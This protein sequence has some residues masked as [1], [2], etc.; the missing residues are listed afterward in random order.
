MILDTLIDLYGKFTLDYKRQ[1]SAKTLRFL[2]GRLALI[3]D[4]LN[5][6]E[7]NLEYFKTEQGIVDLGAE[8]NMSLARLKESDVKIGELDVQLDVI[9]Q[10]EQYVN[11]RNNTLAPIPANAWVID[12]VLS[13]LLR[14][15]I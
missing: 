14:P 10:V 8:G 11:R 9:D 3:A 2:E 13:G 1:L 7:Q 6:V 5:G 15:I 12:G 4:E